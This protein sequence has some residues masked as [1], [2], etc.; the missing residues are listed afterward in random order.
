M[1]RL[2]ESRGSLSSVRV[3]DL[4]TSHGVWLVIWETLFLTWS[5]LFLNVP[6]SSLNFTPYH[7]RRTL[8]FSF[9]VHTLLMFTSYIYTYISYLSSSVSSYLATPPSSL[10][11]LSFHISFVLFSILSAETDPLVSLSTS[12]RLI[13]TGPNPSVPVG[14][15]VTN[16]TWVKSL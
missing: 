4:W 2:L 15:S 13:S 14:V 1:V 16:R 3:I 8:F 10:L 5:T 6:T 12:D 11:P 7:N 9:L